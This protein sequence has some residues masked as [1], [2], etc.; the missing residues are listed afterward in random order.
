[1]ELDGVRESRGALLPGWSCP[2]YVPVPAFQL[3]LL[4][5]LPSPARSPLPAAGPAPRPPPEA[6]PDAGRSLAG[7]WL[8]SLFRADF[9][10]FPRGFSGQARPHLSPNPHLSLI[11]RVSPLPAPGARPLKL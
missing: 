8:G 6:G 11:P 9:E 4:P 3:R 7:H 10:D 2:G 5:W 1:M